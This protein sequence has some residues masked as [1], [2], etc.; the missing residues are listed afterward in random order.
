[1]YATFIV[2]LVFVPVLTMS[3]VQGRLFAPLG[4][5]CILGACPSIPQDGGNRANGIGT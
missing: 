1:V 3:G 5:T 2:A 4:W